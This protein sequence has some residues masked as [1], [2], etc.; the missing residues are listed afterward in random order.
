MSWRRSERH[1]CRSAVWSGMLALTIAVS[2]CIASSG[3]KAKRRRAWSGPSAYAVPQPLRCTMARP[4]TASGADFPIHCAGSGVRIRIFP[5]TPS[6]E[7]V[8]P[9][10]RPSRDRISPIQPRSISANTTPT[11]RP[12]SLRTGTPHIISASF[13]AEPGAK[14]ETANRPFS[15]A[16][17]KKGAAPGIAGSRGGLAVVTTEPSGWSSPRFT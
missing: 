12:S 6:T 1:A 2:P 9:S 11:T 16:R 3:A 4:T 14:S 7:T 13:P 17:L 8:T 15:S 10:G 5:S